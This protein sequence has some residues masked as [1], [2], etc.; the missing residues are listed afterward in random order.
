MLLSSKQ[1]FLERDLVLV[2]DAARYA[3]QTMRVQEHVHLICRLVK[4]LTDGEAVEVECAF[5]RCYWQQSTTRK[6][7]LHVLA[8]AEEA[9]LV[10][11]TKR[12]VDRKQEPLRSRS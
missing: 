1:S 8:F 7:N 9:V 6:K 4:E 10:A 11:V 3:F 12:L 5:E 2:D